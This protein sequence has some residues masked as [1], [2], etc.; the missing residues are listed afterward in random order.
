M[1]YTDDDLTPWYPPEITPLTERAGAYDAK[2]SF[3]STYIFTAHWDGERWRDKFG[4][5]LLLV[6][7]RGLNKEPK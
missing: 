3:F 4:Y 2:W 7:W 5:K 6:Y 1:N